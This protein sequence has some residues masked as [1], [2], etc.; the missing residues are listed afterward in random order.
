MLETLLVVGILVALIVVNTFQYLSNRSTK[1][2]LQEYKDL[3]EDANHSQSKAQA[4]VE[5]FLEIIGGKD[6]LID[7]AAQTIEIATV[8]IKAGA[9]EISVLKSQVGFQEEQYSKLL[10]QKKSSEVRVGH[11]AETMASFLKDYPFPSE[12]G[13]FLGKPLDMIHFL[14]DKIV[15]VEIKSGKSKLSSKQRKIKELIEKG[16]VEFLLYRV[17]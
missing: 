12:T 9:E 4:K 1:S 2:Q 17:Q 7:R 3:F 16:K 13:T 10:G 8:Q 5:E 14:D 15:F 6:V 11:I